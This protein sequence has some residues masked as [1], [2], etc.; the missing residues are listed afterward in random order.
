MQQVRMHVRA[1][2]AT[3]GRISCLILH[4]LVPFVLIFSFQSPYS[5]HGFL[6]ASL[7]PRIR[8]SIHLLDKLSAPLI[9]HHVAIKTRNITV[10]IQFYSLL[11]FEVEEK[12]RASSARAAWLTQPGSP[13]SR[14]ELIEV[15]S[16]L[17]NEPEGMKRRAINLMER[18]ELLGCNHLALD[19]TDSLRQE[20][21]TQLSE[22]MQTLNA[23]SVEK[24]G[25]GLRVA[26]EPR[27]QIIGKS[28]FELAFLFD[29]DGALIEF[30]NKQSNMEQEMS[31]GW[32]VLVWDGKG[33]V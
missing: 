1:I 17:L 21:L 2:K 6:G 26:L 14:L 29:A 11:G 15:P 23:T 24:F 27:Q 12:F 18:Q 22:W 16:Y 9:S 28:V 13:S 10:A 32:E 7:L 8:P 31:S 4:V 25:R 33:F 20:G 3:K 5:A 30:V 19:V